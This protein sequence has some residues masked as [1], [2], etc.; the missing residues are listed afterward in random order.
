MDVVKNEETSALITSFVI[1]LKQICNTGRASL[2]KRTKTNHEDKRIV[3][4]GNKNKFIVVHEDTDLGLQE[5]EREEVV[6]GLETDKDE[7]IFDI[8][9]LYM[10]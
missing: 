9:S 2:L 10:S 6:N 8:L 5:A 7:N 3:K 4:S 1:K